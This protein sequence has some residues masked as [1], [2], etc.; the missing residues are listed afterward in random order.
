MNIG[1]FHIDSMQY[2][3]LVIIIH[4]RNIQPVLRSQTQKSKPLEAI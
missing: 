1:N 3:E 2:C 4:L